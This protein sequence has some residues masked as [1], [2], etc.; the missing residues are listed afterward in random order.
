MVDAALVGLGWWGRNILKAVQGKSGRMR[1]VHAVSKETDE[2]RPLA[3]QH[4]FTLSASLETA[5]EDPRVQ[6]VV[7]A[8]PHSLHADQIVR[9]ASAAKPVFC[10]KPLALTRADAARAV[11]ACAKAGVPIGVGQNKR[12]WPSMEALRAVL[13]AGTLGRVLHI[14]GHYSNENSGLHFSDWRALPSETPGAGMTG[15]GIHILDAFVNACGPVAEVQAQFIATKPSPD[16]RDTVAVLFR[17]AN[18]VSGTLGAVRASPFYWRVHVF[19]DEGSVEALGETQLVVRTRGGRTE[20][21]ELPPRDSL[22]A[23]FEAFADAVEGRAPY[24]IT[25]S[26]MVDT[27][28][29][30]EAITRSIAHGKPV[31]VAE[32]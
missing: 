6:A 4:G 3:E 15:T 32:L 26:E 31:N 22:L 29:A 14:E 20:T 16:P 23:E 19:G 18:G 21:R 13:A 25:P 17:F 8:T 1:F 5:L 12:F 9:T 24:P 27:I 11:A 2:A 10:E 7:L 28:G 30:F